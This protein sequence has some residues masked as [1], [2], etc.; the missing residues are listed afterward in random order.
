MKRL[1]PHAAR[2]SRNT[3]NSLVLGSVTILLHVFADE[4]QPIYKAGTWLAPRL[5]LSINL[6]VPFQE[7]TCSKKPNFVQV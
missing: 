4:S 6:F 1:E 2:P 7:I 5:G 3:L